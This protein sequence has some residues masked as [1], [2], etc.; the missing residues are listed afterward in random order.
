MI[1]II[2]PILFAFLVVALL[3]LLLGIGLAIASRILAVK[4]DKRIVA[5]EEALP[6]TNCGACGFAGCAAYAEAI[7][8]ENEELTLCKP[9]GGEA[10]EAIGEI[11]GVSVEVSH[12]KEVA[13]IHCRGGQKTAQYSYNYNGLKDCN[14]MHILFE[15]NKV[16]KFGCLGLGSCIKVCPTDAIDYD[17]EGLI[18]ID[19]NKCITCGKCID[20]CPTHV[21]KYIPYE[22]DTIVACNS[23]DK[24]ALVRKYCS[25]GCIGCKIC[26]KKSP[27][28]GFVVENFLATIDYSYEGERENAKKACPPKC[29]LSLGTKNE[30]I[31]G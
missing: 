10:A 1:E 24:G 12:M 15:G 27:E 11:M 17:S 28:G 14:G 22:S 20:I 21:I 18:W 6:G 29:I 2:L 16:C 3:G 5:V 19:K 30:D 31:D 8:K 23:T 26:E 4:K 9:G 7:V 13:Q 25:V